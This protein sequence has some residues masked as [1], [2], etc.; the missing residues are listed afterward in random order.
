MTFMVLSNIEARRQNLETAAK[1]PEKLIDTTDSSALKLF[2]IEGKSVVI[3][4]V[5]PNQV[6]LKSFNT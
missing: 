4:L 3:I 2:T 1:A 5:C 6:H